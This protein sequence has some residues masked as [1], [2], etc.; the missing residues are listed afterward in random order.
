MQI[1]D[2]F[3]I[4]PDIAIR[5]HQATMCDLLRCLIRITER[6]K[7]EKR[8][9]KSKVNEL[10]LIDF[11]DIES[12]SLKDDPCFR[13]LS[14]L[15]YSILWKIE[16]CVI[17]GRALYYEGEFD[18]TDLSSLHGYSDFDEYGDH[19]SLRDFNALAEIFDVPKTEKEG[20]NKTLLI[21]YVIGKKDID[22][23]LRAYLK[24]NDIEV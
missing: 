4:Y 18:E 3:E 7:A 23:Y 1:L 9:E 15:D 5:E 11:A 6:E 21:E 17:I 12:V 2:L 16:C 19:V 24:A 13:F 20:G 8:N 10:G 14:Q 22:L